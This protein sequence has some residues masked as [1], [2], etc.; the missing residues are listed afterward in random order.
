M[1]FIGSSVTEVEHCQ[2]ANTQRNS[3]SQVRFYELEIVSPGKTKSKVSE[4]TA[5]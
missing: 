1:S 5:L 2:E 3:F 4:T